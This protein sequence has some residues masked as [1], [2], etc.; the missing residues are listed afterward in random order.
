MI[1]E[2]KRLENGV[3]FEYSGQ[4]F[5]YIH[6]VLQGFDND[7][8]ESLQD[9]NVKFWAVQVINNELPYLSC[10]TI[11]HDL[12]FY[13]RIPFSDIRIVNLKSYEL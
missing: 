13:T 4:F 11:V 12:I 9:S 10:S 2:Q 1:Q 7:Y 5:R 3:I 8:I 6:K